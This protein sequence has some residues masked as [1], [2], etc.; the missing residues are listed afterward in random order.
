MAKIIIIDNYDSFTYN[1]LHYLAEVAEKGSEIKVL[2][3]D[4]CTVADIAAMKPTHLIISPGPCTPDEAGISMAV[5][6]EL[7]P[8]IPLLGICLGHQ[9]IAQAFG[10]KIIRAKSAMHGK[11][12]EISHS[13]SSIF[14]NLPSPLSVTRYHSLAIQ[15]STCPECLDILAESADGEIMAIAH[16]DLP[17]LLGVQFHPEAIL[18]MNGKQL[19]GNFLKLSAI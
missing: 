7:G 11:I 19:L 5:A 14:K 6:K 1:V 9:A 3:N 4:A 8:K 13:N 10:A 18:T 2:R 15:R 17:N 12:C 16:R